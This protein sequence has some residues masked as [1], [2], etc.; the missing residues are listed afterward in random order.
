MALVVS[1]FNH[2]VG[3]GCYLRSPNLSPD[4]LFVFSNLRSIGRH[5]Q[6][7]LALLRGLERVHSAFQRRQFALRVR[8]HQGHEG[9]V[10]GQ[11]GI[12]PART[13]G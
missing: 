1:K 13:A 10:V 11:L 5:A 6:T 8:Q 3:L 12:H 7:M 4:G 2:V 9:V